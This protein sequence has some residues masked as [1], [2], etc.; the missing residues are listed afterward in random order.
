M[1]VMLVASAGGHLAQLLALDSAWEHHERS[2]ATFKLPEVESALEGEKVHWVHFPTTRNIPNAVRNVGVAWK[3]LRE[4]RPDV[5]ISTGA[6]VSVPFFMIA[7]LLGIRT[8]FIEA[9][10]RITMP[11]MSARMCYPLCDLFAVQWDEQRQAFPESVNIG[12][13]L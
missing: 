4:D 10:D 11:T 8:V 12:A 3:A 2:W 13:V 6:A 9:Y 7:K 5:V 1:K